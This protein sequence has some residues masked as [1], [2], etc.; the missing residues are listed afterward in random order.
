MYAI[1]SYY[2][3]KQATVIETPGHT[4]DSISLLFDDMIFT[5]DFL[6]LEDAGAGRDDLP[7]GN[8]NAHW[9]SLQKLV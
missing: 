5:G 8:A 7:G 6:F 2:A 4:D 1:R 9:E 3:G